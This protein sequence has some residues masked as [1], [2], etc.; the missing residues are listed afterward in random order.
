MAKRI[1]IVEDEPGIQALLKLNLS[2]AGY[3][4][5]QAHDVEQAIASVQAAVPD[6]ILLDWNMPGQSGVW[7]VRRLRADAATS[8]I[9][10]IMLTARDDEHDKILALDGGADDYLTKP[11]R[12]RELLARIGAIFRRTGRD[13]GPGAQRNRRE[14]DQSIIEVDGLRLNH[15]QRRVTVGANELTLGPTEYRLLHFFVSHPMRVYSRDELLRHVW[16]NSVE[17]QDRTVDAY[18]GCL[19]TVQIIE[20]IIIFSVNKS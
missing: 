12:V 11:F 18:V 17:L 3:A 15:D 7:F 13:P 20:P 10:V 8:P 2:M 4:V 19:R 1:L 6:L 16:G 9:P 14:T 5:S